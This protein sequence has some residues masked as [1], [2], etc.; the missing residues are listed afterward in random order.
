[1]AFPIGQQF[2]T[3]DAFHRAALADNKGELELRE[4][5]VINRGTIGNTLVRFFRSIG[6]FI[7]LCEKP[8]AAIE[9]QKTVLEAFKSAV[10][11]EFPDAK[12]QCKLPMPIA[13]NL[14]AI[15][16]GEKP[17]TGENARLVTD[18]IGKYYF[19]RAV[20]KSYK[21]AEWP[22]VPPVVQE[23]IDS[24]RAKP[25]GYNIHDALKVEDAVRAFPP[26]APWSW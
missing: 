7:G 13:E 8:P 3:I 10:H 18:Q 26:G 22:V 25:E 9:R 16:I 15:A 21:K 1:M 19:L 6:V 17:L 24:F 5:G 4:E 11:A 2:P 23:A 14:A 20:E 12:G